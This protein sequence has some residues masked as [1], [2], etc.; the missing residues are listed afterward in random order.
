MS[1]RKNKYIMALLVCVASATGILSPK[2]VAQASGTAYNFLDVTSSAKIYGLGGVNISLVDDDLMSSDQNPALLGQECSGQIGID[3]MHYMGGSNFAGLRYAQGAG[4]H[5]TWSAHVR[6][7]GYGSME[8]R[9]EFGEVIGSFSPQDV[10][11]GGS[12][13]HDFN[14]RLRGGIDL[15]LIYSGYA[16]YT[17]FA[18]STDLGINYY[19]PDKD[20]SLSAVIANA[21][22]Q[23]KRFTETYA[24]LPFDIRLGWSQTFGSFPV[25]FSITAWN[26]TKWKMPYYSTGDGSIDSE[27]ELKDGFASNL[28][29]HLV[30]G[31]DLISSE[32]FY[33]GIGYNY[34]TRTD[35][36]TYKRSFFSG[37][38]LAAGL[39]V[40]SFG[41]GL[42]FAQPHSGATT[43]MVNLTCNLQELIR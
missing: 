26:L 29:R 23:V 19:D 35:M 12:Y 5:G 31:A 2:S 25:R 6:Y 22:G 1:I 38:S 40:K 3:Y 7:F 21:G 34:K 15:K 32:N 30:F 20:L 8:E 36:S 17:A 27:A 11:F 24:R 10:A 9:N 14:D 33:I 16:D 4:D 39:R 37:L 28:F 18:V 42:A 41:V 13:S 43:L